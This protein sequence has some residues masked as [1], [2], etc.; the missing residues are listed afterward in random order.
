MIDATPEY[1]LNVVDEETAR[2]IWNHLAGM[3]IYFPEKTIKHEM[4]K[5]DF[6]ALQKMQYKPQDAVQELSCKYNISKCQLW[7]I[8]NKE[9][10]LF[11]KDR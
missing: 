4:I 8:I 10:E 5:K 11:A 9:G 3:R 6:E 7:R 1:L 2:K